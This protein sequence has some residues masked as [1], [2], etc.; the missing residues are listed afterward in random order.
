MTEGDVIAGL[1][2]NMQRIRARRILDMAA[3]IGA[4]F[5]ES[6]PRD[7]MLAAGESG[8]AAGRAETEAFNAKHRERARQLM[9]RGR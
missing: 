4:A 3:S 5:A 7:L 6:P 1:E 9:G 2:A 8:A